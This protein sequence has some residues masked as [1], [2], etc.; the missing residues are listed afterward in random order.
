MTAPSPFFRAQALEH[1]TR[2]Q[3]QAVLPRLV[4]QLVTPG[5]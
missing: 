5:C 4:D 1:N 2:R 3:D